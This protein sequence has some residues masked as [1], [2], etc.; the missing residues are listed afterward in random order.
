[1]NWPWSLL[2]RDLGW[3]GSGMLLQGSVQEPQ[4][5]WG[6]IVGAVEGRV[7]LVSATW[8]LRGL[9]AEAR[10]QK[11]EK[12]NAVRQKKRNKNNPNASSPHW[13]T[14]RQEWAQS[15]RKTKEKH[16]RIRGD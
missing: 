1:M 13:V 8:D 7:D 16:S 2:R 14:S 9:N 3:L 15:D 4:F 5:S 10:S 6:G 12:K 11:S